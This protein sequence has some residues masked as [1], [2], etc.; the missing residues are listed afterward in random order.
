MPI[1]TYKC[2]K[3]NKIFEYEQKIN[4][5]PLKFCP[6]D[7]CEYQPAGKGEVER[8]ISKDI[9]LIFKGSGFYVTDYA[10]K[11]GD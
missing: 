10:H 11:N 7:I 6:E 5:E 4:D 1:Y 8:I 2:K 9:G 3:C